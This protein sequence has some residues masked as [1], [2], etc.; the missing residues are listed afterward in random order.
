[1]RIATTEEV[2]H[3]STSIASPESGIFQDSRL[4]RPEDSITRAEFLKVLMRALACRYNLPLEVS[5]T[6]FT[7]IDTTA[8]YAPYIQLAHQNG[9]ISGYSDNTF[10]PHDPITRQEA[11]KIIVNVIGLPKTQDLTIKTDIPSGSEFTPALHTLHAYGI[12][13]GDPLPHRA[14]AAFIRFRPESTLSRGEMARV[15]DR[16]LFR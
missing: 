7:D 1:L 11:A 4:F 14:D 2:Y 13:Q 3:L 16:M 8:W 10:R 5:R 12:F 15:L 9:W 6:D